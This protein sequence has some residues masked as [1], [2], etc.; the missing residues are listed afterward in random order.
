MDLRD[1]ENSAEM[2]S[3]R[4]WKP[5]RRRPTAATAFVTESLDY[6]VTA[7]RNV[8][9]RSL[10]PSQRL[11]MSLIPFAPRPPLAT[12]SKLWAGRGGLLQDAADTPKAFESRRP[13]LQFSYPSVA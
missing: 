13:P 1:I 9:T 5:R 10:L 11:S 12:A 4:A 8:E 3:R 7:V 2:R 6:G